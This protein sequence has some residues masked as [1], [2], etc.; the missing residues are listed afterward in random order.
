ML[1]LLNKNEN[2]IIN[3][4]LVSLEIDVDNDIVLNIS[5]QKDSNVYIKINKA[6]K[7]DLDINV[8][9]NVK[10][11]ILIWNDTKDS[12]VTK[13]HINVKDNANLTLAYADINNSNVDRKIIVDLIEKYASADVKTACLTSSDK[14]YILEIN[15]KAPF[16]L[17]QMENFSVV[18]KDGNYYM[19]ATGRILKGCNG[20]KS[21]Q[22][23]RALCFDAK[24][25]ATILPQLLIDE[26]D[27]EASHATSVGSVDENQ[28]FYMQTRGLTKKEVLSLIAVGYLSFITD[29]IDD[30]ELKNSIIDHIENKVKEIC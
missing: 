17:G 3:D 29:V 20:S 1:K 18:L 10:S 15:S 6:D 28:L 30:E 21:H 23:S 24:Q 16:T 11:S 12:L 14:K 2:I 25:K 4:H 19:D 13:E 7:I 26:N 27:V 8:E 9:A 22:T 5:V